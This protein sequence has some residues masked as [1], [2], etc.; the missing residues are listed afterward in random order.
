MGAQ[1]LEISSS[2][3][4][5]EAENERGTEPRLA[6]GR[7]ARGSTKA[8]KDEKERERLQ[9]DTQKRAPKYIVLVGLP[10]SG[11]TTFASAL[12]ASD[13]WI[14][15]NQ[16]EQGGKGCRDVA[17][18][19]VPLV[20]QGRAR[21]VI[22]RCNPTKADRKEW[23]DALCGPPAREVTC[24]FFDKPVEDCKQRAASRI[25]HPTIKTGGGA[26]IIE[27][28]VK[29]IEVPT[30]DEGFGAVERIRSF[31]E[32]NALLARYG[33]GAPSAPDLLSLGGYAAGQAPPP[34]APV[35]A[36]EE[37]SEAAACLLPSSFSDWLKLTLAQEVSAADAEGLFAAVE[38]ILGNADADSEALKSASEVLL[39]GGAP[40]CAEG[41]SERWLVR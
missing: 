2:S 37:I 19:T 12:E 3:S 24:V 28:I 36:E 15:A 30:T 23:L 7:G 21:L 16:D 10:G 13:I 1:L 41:L 6:A 5:M 17:R 18:R 33:V 8:K 9:K 31:E 22:D 40:E 39:D 4:V 11:K 25:G 32:S 27:S 20:R 26:R 35:V 38:V 14:R 34:V 29:V